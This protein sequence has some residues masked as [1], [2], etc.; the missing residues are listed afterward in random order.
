MNE[1][2]RKI[3]K[4]FFDKSGIHVDFLK[5]EGAE[6]LVTPIPEIWQESVFLKQERLQISQKLTM[7]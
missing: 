4:D 3:Q 2:K 5:P 7:F 6:E 1:R